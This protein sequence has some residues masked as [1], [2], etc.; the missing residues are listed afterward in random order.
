[1]RAVGDLHLAGVHAIDGMVQLLLELG[2]GRG[3]VPY[4]PVET[5][6]PKM[7]QRLVE[8]VLAPYL[9]RRKVTR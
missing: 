5:A 8:E 6:C 3:P 1:M 2:D 7:R 4:V 9:G